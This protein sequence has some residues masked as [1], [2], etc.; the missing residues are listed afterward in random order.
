[1]S[2]PL[3]EHDVH[4]DVWALKLRKSE[5]GT[6]QII[7]RGMSSTMHSRGLFLGFNIPNLL[8]VCLCRMHPSGNPISYFGFRLFQFN[9]TAVNSAQCTE[10]RRSMENITRSKQK[11]SCTVAVATACYCCLRGFESRPSGA[12]SS[13]AEHRASHDCRWRTRFCDLPMSIWVF[14]VKHKPV[15]V[16][17]NPSRWVLGLGFPAHSL[18]RFERG[19][20]FRV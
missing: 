13:G 18:I 9:Y 1:M 3:H 12:S 4:H 6:E 20:G 16:F 11:N 14:F 17:L 10:S 7:S 5:E 15:V 19:L 2:P 8:I